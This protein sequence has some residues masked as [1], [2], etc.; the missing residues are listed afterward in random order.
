MERELPLDLN[1]DFVPSICYNLYNGRFRLAEQGP[2]S[3][4]V[5]VLGLIAYILI[6]LVHDIIEKVRSSNKEGLPMKTKI[7]KAFVAVTS[8]VL[9][10]V[11][12]VGANLPTGALLV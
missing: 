9:N 3:C 1:S 6:G 11:W 5:I 8:S 2:Q 4:L 10:S 7:K 12:I